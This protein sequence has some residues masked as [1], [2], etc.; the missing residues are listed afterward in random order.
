MP[1]TA[2][3]VA[4]FLDAHERRAPVSLGTGGSSG[5]PRS[6]V[7]STDSWVRSF[8]HVSALAGIDAHARIWVPGPLTATMNL[9][10]TVHAVWAGA[11]LVTRPDAATHAQLTP[12]ALRRLLDGPSTLPPLTVVVAGDRLPASLAARA[13]AA[14]L[15]VH[16]YYGAAELSFV[17]WGAHEE[18]LRPFP[19]VEVDVRDG[20]VWVRSAY[21]CQRYDGAPGPLRWDGEGFATVGDRGRVQAD[22]LVLAGREGAVTT[23]GVTVHLADVEA[24]LRPAAS[25]EVVV[26]GVPQEHLGE[27]LTVVLTEAS[28]HRVLLGTARSSLDGAH[29]PRQWF[30]VPTLPRTGAGKVDRAALAGLLAPADRPRDRQAARRLV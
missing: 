7:R 1:A 20:V 28:D 18:D 16:H 17:A 25:G 5:A 4:A 23:A 12:T 10:A 15:T 24:V 3:P 19:G 30:H 6:V 11:A 21:L 8:R 29:R 26:L 9:F 14:G 2:D 13:V 22:R 27:T